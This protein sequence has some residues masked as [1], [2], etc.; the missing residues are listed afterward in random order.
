VRAFQRPRRAPHATHG[1]DGAVAVIVALLLAFALIPALALGTGTY[2]R[3]STSTELQR[4]ADSGALAG[5]AEIPLGDINFAE[6]YLATITGTGVVTTLQSLGVQNA[7][8]LPDPL[9]DACKVALADATNTQNLASSYATFDHNSL[10]PDPAVTTTSD[11]N[12]WCKAKYLTDAGVLGSAQNCINSIGGL[13]NLG[14][15]SLLNL[16]LGALSPTKLLS[17]LDGTLPALLEPGIQ[18]TT[19]WKVKAPFDN[20]FNSDGSTQTSTSIARRLFKNAVVV[21]SIP[22]GGTTINVNPTLQITRT[23]LLST[24]SSVES[25]LETL[26]GLVPGLASCAAIIDNLSGDLADAVDPPDNGPSLQTL[27]D[28]AVADTADGHPVLAVSTTVTGL[29]V[30]FLDIVPV[31]ME[32]T[33]TNQYVAHLTSFGTCLVNAPGAFRAALRNS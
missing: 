3:S 22:I 5:A 6:N 10:P 24:L 21:P 9:V 25:L 30:P 7:G 26:G 29:G 4:A 27:L 16:G 31:C 12:A 8:Q 2:V 32:K 28:N 19:S 13:N 18:V 20:V 23:Q 14:L 11:P 17:A 15:L 33:A 1:D